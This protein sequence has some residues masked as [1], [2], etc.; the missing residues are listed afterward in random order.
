MV[1]SHPPV[2]VLDA[3]VLTASIRRHLLLVCAE[4]RLFIPVWSKQIIHETRRAIPK[5]LNASAVPAH[6]ATQHAETVCTL[7]RAAFPEAEQSLSYNGHL[8]D[9]PDPD[10][11]HVVALALSAHAK[12][13]VTENLRDFPS[14]RLAPFGISAIN[15]DAFLSDL[16]ARQ[17][18]Q[19]KAIL[20]RLQRAIDRAEIDQSRMI[21]RMKSVGL[22]N[23]ARSFSTLS[24]NR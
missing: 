5:A 17:P 8:P 6:A 22:K 18:H 19:K 3:C 11:V 10:D 1:V 15:A 13:I 23:T 21:S 16:F 9:L 12:I 7:M 2:I 4:A 20:D 24:Q 14:R